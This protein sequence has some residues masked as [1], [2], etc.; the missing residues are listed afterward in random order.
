MPDPVNEKVQRLFDSPAK[1]KTDQ[2]KFQKDVTEA[3]NNAERR[4]CNEQL[5]TNC[6]EAMTKAFSKNE[7]L[8]EIATKTSDPAFVAANLQNWLNDITVRNDE[9]G[10]SARKYI[11]QCP[12][13]ER[14]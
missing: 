2:N 13:T 3:V 5:V 10:M 14:S 8:L 1:A 12:N 11:E 7:Q 6:E 4:V 9:I